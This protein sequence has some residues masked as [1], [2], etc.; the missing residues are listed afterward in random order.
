MVL[1]ERGAEHAGEGQVARQ[2]ATV[3]IANAGGD[4]PNTHGDAVLRAA[5]VLRLAAAEAQTVVVVRPRIGRCLDVGA[6]PSELRPQPGQGGV[7]SIRPVSQRQKDPSP[8]V[9]NGSPKRL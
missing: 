6:P 2:V 4:A 1:G 5:G 8:P 7:R 9:W 3:P